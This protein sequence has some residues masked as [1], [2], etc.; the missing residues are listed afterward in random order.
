MEDNERNKQVVSAYDQRQAA[1]ID[2]IADLSRLVFG[3]VDELL[4]AN[5]QLLADGCYWIQP[6]KP[7]H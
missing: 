4:L 5:R 1:R 2:A 7:L 6:S 3:S